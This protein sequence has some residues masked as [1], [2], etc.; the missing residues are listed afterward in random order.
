[1]QATLAEALEAKAITV[2]QIQTTSNE[3][4]YF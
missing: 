4:F 3:I 2:I 1:M